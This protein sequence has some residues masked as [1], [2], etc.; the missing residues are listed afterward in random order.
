[1]QSRIEPP[2]LLSRLLLFVFAGCVVVLFVMFM[3]LENMFPLNRPEVFFITSKPEGASVIQITELPPNNQNLEAYKTAFVMEYI[4]ERNEI[5]N[6]SMMRPRWDANGVV[7]SWSSPAVYKAF[8]ET[9]LY[10]AIMNDY[11]D[12]EFSCHVNFVG[13]PLPLANNRY[14]V[15]FEY[16][17]KDSN[18][19]TSQKSYTIQ[20]GL[21][22][23]NDAQIKWGE[24]LNNPLGVKVSYYFIQDNAGDPLD[25]VYK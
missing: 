21:E 2:V 3:T 23:T 25:T 7:A 20:V 6:V 12:F 13:K 17:C 1:M 15:R 24:R 19:Q 11:P 10:K 5:E 9:G 22:L 8:S 18:G 16:F 14:T 4:R